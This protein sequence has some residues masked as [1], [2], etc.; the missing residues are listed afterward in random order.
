[1]HT[2]VALIMF[3]RPDTTARVFAEIAKAKPKQL[4]VI[5]DGPRTGIPGE[6]EKCMASRAVI[7]RVDW[8]CEVFRNFSDINLGC[9]YRPAT[10]INWVF[11]H[12]SEA[13]I[14]EDD[15]VPHPSF[16]KFCEE[17]LERYRDDER[18]A[19][20]SGYNLVHGRHASPYSYWFH[21]IFACWGWATWRRAWQHHDMKMSIWPELRNTT[22]LAD[23]LGDVRASEYFAKIFDEA[24]AKASTVDYWDYQ[25]LFSTWSQN[26]LAVAPSTNLV[27]NIGF[28]EDA[29]HTV[30]Q[31]DLH[32]KTLVEAMHFPLKH[33]PFV[34]CDR[35]ADRLY[36]S[37][38]FGR[39][40]S[41]SLLNRILSRARAAIS[42]F[43]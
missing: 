13:I 18:V 21:Q 5:A 19:V 9:G 2:A 6:E 22:W 16:F 7:D 10:G 3:N 34:I 4:F 20:I 42:R 12:V 30:S 17:L 37:D 27:S 31:G 11:E 35:V 41:Q 24:Y 33:P 29:T 40:G 38:H 32:A 8:E 43:R 36:L 1:M 23:H 14:I 15:C 25:L 39:G 26:G 28:R